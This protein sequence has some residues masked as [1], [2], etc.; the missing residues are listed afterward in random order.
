[1]TVGILA[2]FVVFPARPQVRI[3]KYPPALE[4][5]SRCVFASER[6]ISFTYRTEPK[7]LID[8]SFSILTNHPPNPPFRTALAWPTAPEQ[9]AVRKD[10]GKGKPH[11]LRDGV[12]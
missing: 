4:G 7:T 11:E 9:R 1:M 6:V 10:G 3:S 2:T 12:G 5:F 8:G